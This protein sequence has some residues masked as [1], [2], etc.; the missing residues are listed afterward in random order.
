MEISQQLFTLVPE[1]SPD[2]IELVYAY[3]YIAIHNAVIWLASYKII[4]SMLA[5]LIIR[6]GSKIGSGKFGMVL[7]GVWTCDEKCTQVAIK[8]LH[9]K[10]SE[11]EKTKL[12]TE[13]A[14]IGQF[15]HMNIVRLH[16]VVISKNSQVS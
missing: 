6:S 1:L 11:E 15:T 9:S 12:L 16:G 5:T 14:I 7:H 4:L 3:V 10:V 8:T 2:S 13:A